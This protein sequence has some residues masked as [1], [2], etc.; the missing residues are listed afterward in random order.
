MRNIYDIYVSINTSGYLLKQI[1]INQ[2]RINIQ[3]YMSDHPVFH[4]ISI[5]AYKLVRGGRNSQNSM[6]AFHW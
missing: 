6:L 5:D 1:N 4:D 3:H 2:L